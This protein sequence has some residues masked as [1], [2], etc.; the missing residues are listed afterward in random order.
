M[1]LVVLYNLKFRPRSVNL[2][3]SSILILAFVFSFKISDK[4]MSMLE[5]R[6]KRSA[7]T[8]KPTNSNAA[9]SNQQQKPEPNYPPLPIP[10][11]QQQQQQLYEEVNNSARP[12][13]ANQGRT[14]VRTPKKHIPSPTQ[15]IVS[16]FNQ[17]NNT[18]TMESPQRQEQSMRINN[19]MKPPKREF[20]LDIEDDED[21]RSNLIAVKLTEHRDI[22]DLLNKPV[23]LPPKK[24]V[25]TFQ[26]NILKDTQD[27]KDAIDL[28]ITY[29][30]NH[31]LETSMSN[32]LQIDVVIKDQQKKELLIPHIDN[33]LN[34][35]AVKINTAH[36]VYL[37]NSEV[38]TEDVFKLYKCIFHC[39]IDLFDNGLGKTASVR[40][41]KDLFFHLLTVMTDPK[42]VDY[43]EGD[44]L[45]KAI[46]LVTLK[47]LEQT[48]Q[49]TCYCSLVRLLAECCNNDKISQKYS[50]LVM[51]CIWR[52]IRRLGPQN[53]Q[54]I[55]S[56]SL[57]IQ[58][59]HSNSGEQLIKQLDCQ[60]IL[61]EIHSF[62]K[63]YPASSWLS[64]SS[65]LPLRTIKTLVFHLAKARQKLILDDLNALR[66]PDDAELKSYIMKLFRND[67]QLN[68]TNQNNTTS[69]QT[70]NSSFGFAKTKQNNDNL[71]QSPPQN[72]NNTSSF[73]QQR[74]GDQLS[75]ILRKISIPDQSKEGLNELYDFKK[76]NP[77]FEINKYFKN[78]SGR[79]EQ[80]I[81]EN[82][83]KI[84]DERNSKSPSSTSSVGSS[85]SYSYKPKY[86]PPDVTTTTTTNVLN[87]NGVRK[88]DDIM[89]SLADWKSKSKNQLNLLTDNDSNNENR[90]PATNLNRFLSGSNSGLSTNTASLFNG[91]DALRVEGPEKYRNMVQDIKRKY[92]K[93]KTES[94][95]SSLNTANEPVSAAPMQPHVGQ[96]LFQRNDLQRDQQQE[97]TRPVVAASTATE[98]NT[99]SNTSSALNGGSNYAAMPSE[100]LYNEYKRRLEMIK[101]I[102]TVK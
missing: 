2:K 31:D 16:S 48:E 28:V 99:T 77:G 6:I 11:L 26:T 5:E 9:L 84:E 95:I 7:K 12:G 92:G 15:P 25:K 35:L 58:Q 89:R 74:L 100:N 72:S 93:S 33:L 86:S 57:T 91:A 1:I 43:A 42:I 71:I 22:D 45:I 82:L 94:I 67:F 27:C 78:S 63:S 38:K 54:P 70:I 56:Q 10:S 102:K 62:F 40:T 88:A 36:N 51:K 101:N 4:D 68:Q 87:T 97:T 98:S 50:E 73:V 8:V 49:T 20:N 29:I 3:V 83:K 14:M 13:L 59:F 19:N 64:K 80:Y 75:A 37:N 18:I 17:H 23:E 53:Q 39:I 21:D 76:H 52:Q 24:T 66:I 46:N 44:N 60:R 41:I 85:S 34:T 32:L 61:Q 55:Q 65:D 69:N 96:Q 30:S 90:I 47:L 79:L 81:E